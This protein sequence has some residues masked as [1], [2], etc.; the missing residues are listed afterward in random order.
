M[1]CREGAAQLQSELQSLE[2]QESSMRRQLEHKEQRL[3]AVEGQIQELQ[4]SVEE[5][6]AELSTEL[7]N[8]LSAVERQE[9]A[10]LTPRL[11]QLQVRQNHVRIMKSVG[12][13]VPVRCLLGA[14]HVC[15]LLHLLLS[16]LLGRHCCFVFPHASAVG[17]SARCTTLRLVL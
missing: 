2:Q 3:Q 11:K 15:K 1:V 5:H 16:L 6:K 8:H 14:Q 12:L 4:Q 7:H 17:R 10:D 13:L 9:L